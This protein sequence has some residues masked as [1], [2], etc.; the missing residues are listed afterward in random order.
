M[1]NKKFVIKGQAGTSLNGAPAALSLSSTYLLGT[2]NGSTLG[3]ST[4]NPYDISLGMNQ[5][6]SMPS[7][8]GKPNLTQKFGNFMESPLG[9]ITSQVGASVLSGIPT[10]DKDI[11]SVDGTLGGVR[12]SANKALMSGVAGP[13]GMAAG[14]A[15]MLVGKL[16]GNSDASSGLGGGNDILNGIASFT[17]GL[18]FFAKKIKPAEKSLELQQ[19]SGFAG[20]QGNI[21]KANKNAGKILF[22]RGK[23]KRRIADAQSKADLATDILQTSAENSAAATGSADMFRLRNML[24]MQDNSYLYNGALSAKKGGRIIDRQ[25]SAIE[26]AVKKHQ[27]GGTFESFRKTLPE[28][29]QD[30]IYYKLQTLWEQGGKPRNFEQAVKQ[31]LFTKETDGYHAPSVIKDRK[32]DEYHFLKVPSH[33]TISKE[34]DW[35]ESEDGKSF[36]EQYDLDKTSGNWKYIRKQTK[37]FK[38]GGKINV[39]PSGALHAHKHNLDDID[40]ITKKGVPVISEEEGG[41]LQHAEIE[42]DEIIFRK[43][44]TKKLEELAKLGTDEAAIEAG[45]LL[46]LEIIENT[47][48]NTGL[49]DKVTI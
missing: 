34:L 20:L 11:N 29:L 25:L 13:W 47:Q 41:V 31:K 43:E 48:D 14:A 10:K 18:G 26:K 27:K 44:V 21:D 15:N 7:Y 12:D 42:R 37:E 33:P 24:G 35:Y 5:K 1:R 45:K 40:G 9:G 36:R 49:M 4:V 38:E 28:P 3:K 8:A 23:A 2:M 19:S 30:T 6:S 17:P 46:T 22:G 32:L 39:I 16:G